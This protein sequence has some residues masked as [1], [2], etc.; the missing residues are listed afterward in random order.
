MAVSQ[1]ISP[2]RSGLGGFL[3]WGLF[4]LALTVVGAAVFFREGIDEL[5][6]A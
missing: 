4:W 1:D 2:Q 5:L 3:T 6:R